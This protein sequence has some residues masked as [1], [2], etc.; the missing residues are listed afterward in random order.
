MMSQVAC[1]AL[2]GLNGV[3]R[4]CLSEVQKIFSSELVSGIFG[5]ISYISST[6]L[7]NLDSR[8]SVVADLNA[9]INC[10]ARTVLRT[11]TSH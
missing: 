4:V 8:V 11:F 1:R 2:F 7:K 10:V 5:W 9:V 6:Q 3:C